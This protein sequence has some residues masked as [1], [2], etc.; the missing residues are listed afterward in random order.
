MIRATFEQMPARYP[1]LRGK[2]AVVTGAGRGIGQGIA[3]RLARE[4]MRVVVAGLDAAEVAATADGLDAC[5]AEALAAPG[6]LRDPAVIEALFEQTIGAFGALHLLVNN[7]AD[8]RRVRAA[9]LT[10]E[11]IE[12]QL[13]VN[14]RAP[15][16]CAAKALALMRAGSSIVNVTSVGGLRAQLPGLPY[17]MTKGALE[18]LTRNLATDAGEYGVRVNAVAPGWTPPASDGSAEFEDY[19]RAMSPYVPLR[20]PGSAADVAA[21]VAFLASDDAAYV[22]GHTL[23]VDGGLVAQL[24]PPEHPI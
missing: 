22:T 1:E 12:D 17:G 11:L 6:D 2:V 8:L 16:L 18:S 10:P 24:H 13:A 20:R 9:D 23:V 19:L 15:L 4:G 21:A 14:V 3:G 5:G 7:A